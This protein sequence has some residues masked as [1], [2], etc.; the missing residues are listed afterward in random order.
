MALTLVRLSEMIIVD[1]SNVYFYRP[2]G[3]PS[4]FCDNRWNAFRVFRH[5]INGNH[6]VFRGD[7]QKLSLPGETFAKLDVVQARRVWYCMKELHIL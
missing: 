6:F 1:D 5:I 4:H 2:I 3:V 7:K